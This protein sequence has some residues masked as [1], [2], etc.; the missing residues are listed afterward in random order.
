VALRAIIFDFDGLIL[1]T[2]SAVYESWCHVYEEHRQS[3]PM[4]AW[5]AAV[6]TRHGFDAYAFLEGLLGRPIDREAARGLRD[7]RYATLR[8]SL[9]LLE[10]VET[11]IR[12]AR[13]AGLGLAVASSSDSEWVLG[14]MERFGIL[15][16]FDA[17]VC[18]SDEGL[19]AKPRPDVY[20]EAA[21]RLRVDVTEA[22]ALEDSPKG[23][24][25]AKAAG[26]RCIAVPRGITAGL[27]VS[28][29]DAVVSS[30]AEISLARLI[31][32]WDRTPW[33][34]HRE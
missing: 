6:G 20:V 30:L 26:M 19:P 3:L 27:D 24:A 28:E 21:M 8:E 18:A 5:M 11:W 25:A 16:S 1:D 31:A 9:S 33:E 17:V 29:A 23:I 34:L 22:L 32:T 13:E 14:H 15:E 7:Q 4:D 10:G 12:D 2:E